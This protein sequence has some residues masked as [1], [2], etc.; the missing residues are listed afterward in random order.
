MNNFTIALAANYNYVDKVLTTIKSI[1]KYNN[2]IDFYILNDDYPQEWFKYIESKL[3]PFNSRVFDI[4][5]KER[6]DFSL[7]ESHITKETFYRYY[8]PKYIKNNIVLYLDVDLIVNGDLTCLKNFNFDNN[9]C[10]AV[11][12]I[13]LCDSFNAGVLLIN[14]L[15]CR[16][17][18]IME[19]LIDYTNENGK[20][21]DLVDQSVLNIIFKDKW[22][23]LDY[24]YNYQV[25]ALF[26]FQLYNQIEEFNSYYKLSKNN[27]LIIHYTTAHKPW[28][29]NSS[30]IFRELWWEVYASEWSDILKFNNN[31]SKKKKLFTL[32]N[33]A[34]I[35]KL[36]HIIK[37][38]PEYEIVVGAYTLFADNILE[39][40]KYLNLKVYQQILKPVVDEILD[41]CV[42][43]LDINHYDE[44]DN[45]ISKCNVMNKPVFAFDVTN[46]DT[47][48]RS[49]VFKVDEV[50]KMIE[51]IKKL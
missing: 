1:C 3:K 18:N 11:S 15:K 48:G 19:K 4:K 26:V 25:G 44:V 21:L 22:I 43:Y 29:S 46:H 9:Y 50:D 5:V 30:G 16:E 23:K 13:G 41:E 42:A 2:N 49:K 27:P 39:M 20:N 37:S 8:I 33:T 35:E 12:D 28:I 6:Y 14:N 40:Q 38:M 51:E 45:I 36:E 34:N 47:T 32:T 10:A 7:T 17:E 24:K 31:V